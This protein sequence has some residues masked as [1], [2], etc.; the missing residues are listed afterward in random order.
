[1]SRASSLRVN[2]GVTLIELIVALT[3]LAIIVALA[4]PSFR[5]FAERR[6]V[7]G[8][9]N[10]F[11]SAIGLAKE[12]AIKRDQEIRLDFNEFG[13]GVCVGVSLASAAACDCSSST[14]PLGAYPT[15]QREL[16]MV[17]LVGTP[18]F[19]GDTAFSIDPKTGML[20][21]MDDNEGSVEFQTPLGYGITIEMNAMVRPRMCSSG[22]KPLPG[23]RSC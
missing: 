8:L 23:M 21:D 3:V 9:A 6:A 20:S 22:S 2:R 13:D 10:G 7:L 12:E 19:G 14:C 15:E 4:L 5:D 18:D 11:V 1:M 16:R 17:S